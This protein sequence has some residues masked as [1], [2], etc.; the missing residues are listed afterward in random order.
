MEIPSFLKTT[1]IRTKQHLMYYLGAMNFMFVY[2]ILAYSIAV[3]LMD[4]FPDH[5]NAIFLVGLILGIS[6]FFALFVDS[7]WGYFQKISDPKKLLSIAIIGLLITVLIFLGS[8]SKVVP[9]FAWP[10]FTVIAA[11][12][13]G[14]SYDLYEITMTNIILNRSK[15]SELAQELSQKKVAESIGMIFGLLLGGILLYFGSV[16]AQLFLVVFLTIL[17]GFFKSHFEEEAD[18]VLLKFSDS[19]PIE[20]KTIMKV[21]ANPESVSKYLDSA[22]VNMKNKVLNIS[23][24]LSNELKKLPKKSQTTAK[25]GKKLIEEGRLFLLDI[26]AKENELVRTKV[27]KRDFHFK[28]MKEEIGNAFHLFAYIFKSSSRFALWWVALV[29]MFF[30]FWDTMAITFQPLF[31]ARF[32]DSL[33]IFTAFILPLFVLPIFALQ[34]PFSRIADRIGH[35]KMVVFGLVLSALSLIGLGLLDIAFGGSIFALLICGLGN[36][37]G[38]AAAFAPAQAKFVNEMRQSM[39]SRKEKANNAEISSVLRLAL[40]I[41][42]IL[43]QILGGIIFAF[44]GFLSGFLMFGVLLLLLCFLSF[45]FFSKLALTSQDQ[46]KEISE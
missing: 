17:Y 1:T 2:T 40:N 46:T 21:I 28:E 32:Q 20:W 18:A 38:Y 44:L 35:Y 19:S 15:N 9:P 31:L 41:G 7:I 26:L 37:V 33:G 39:I 12:S 29:V 13:Y 34:M 30:S 8:G 11:F 22:T 6:S 43:G 36:S 14:W 25:N 24:S 5:P 42:N 23:T 4:Q 10:I 45:V 16:V 27:P 3:F